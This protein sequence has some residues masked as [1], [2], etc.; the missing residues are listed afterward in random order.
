TESRTTTSALL[1]LADA[2]VLPFEFTRAA[3]TYRDYADQIA[4]EA[5][6]Q[7]AT[8]NLD[9][10]AVYAALDHLDTAAARYESALSAI[11]GWSD[12]GVRAHWNDLQK[13]NA[14]LAHAEQAL[15]SDQGLPDRDWFHH[16]IYAPGFFTGYGVK[17][18]AGIREA[19]E[20]VPN[21]QVAQA[22]A[23]RVAAALE[24]YAGKVDEAARALENIR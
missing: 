4:K 15:T 19:V 10:S 6:N 20:D 16:L 23:A 14:P 17:T 5:K 24:R 22:Q 7:D 3:K 9:L 11:G 21:G 12:R 8:K 18:M 2:P 1:R 13:V